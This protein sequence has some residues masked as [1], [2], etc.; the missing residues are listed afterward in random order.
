MLMADCY[1]DDR[2]EVVDTDTGWNG[3]AGTIVS[4]PTREEQFSVLVKLPDHRHFIE[5]WFLPHDLQCRICG[6]HI[7]ADTTAS[8]RKN[9]ALFRQ[10]LS[11]P[12]HLGRSVGI[13][14]RSA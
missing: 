1:V 8:P 12:L 9:I 10:H 11:D 3:K 2:V 5:L 14:R 6:H 4:L 13:Q 7:G